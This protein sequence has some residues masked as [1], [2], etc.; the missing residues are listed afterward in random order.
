MESADVERQMQNTPYTI[1][2]KTQKRWIVLC[3]AFAAMFSPLS[4][5]IYYPAIHSLAADLHTS[6]ENVNLSI[7][8]Y[9][10]V[11][12]ITPAMLG[13]AADQIGRRPIYTFAFL[14]YFFA[15]VGLALQQ[16]YPALLI[17]RMIQSIGSSGTYIY[18][19]I[20]T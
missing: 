1:F 7:T 6:V 16:S 15:N 3:I 2:S 9:M 13:D 17:L 18:R 10:I 19:N 4:S 12:G 20:K 11:S 8:V 5:F 14:I